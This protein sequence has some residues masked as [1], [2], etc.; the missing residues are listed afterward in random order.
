MT[1]FNPDTCHKIIQAL[2]A[3][4]YRKTAAA[5]AGV[6]ESAFYK[7]I[8]KGTTNKSGKYVEFV[9]SVK[10]AEEKAKAYHL[11]QIRKASENGSWQASAWYLERK[12][13]KEWGRKQ[14]VDMTADVKSEIKG[15]VEHDI[16]KLPDDPELRAGLSKILRQISEKTD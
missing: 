5:L 11:Q 12:H 4:N 9:E 8:E 15:K 16:V 1:K 7:W 2:E 14:Q 3:G 10:R 13:Y 6:S